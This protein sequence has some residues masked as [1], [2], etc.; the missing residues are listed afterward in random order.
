MIFKDFM[1]VVQKFFPCQI[2]TQIMHAHPTPLHYVVF[3]DPFA[4]W[5]IYFMTCKPTSM[6][7]HGYIIVSMD[8]FTK[9]VVGFVF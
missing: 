8:Y 9:W 6:N 3:I 1:H 4:K 2:F 7:G 5:G